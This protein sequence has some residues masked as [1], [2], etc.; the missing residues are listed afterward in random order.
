MSVEKSRAG[1]IGAKRRST[2]FVYSDYQRAPAFCGFLP[3]VAGIHGV[4][5]WAFYVNRGQA[6]VSFGVGSKDGSI[7]RYH[8]AVDAYR[9]VSEEGFRTFLKV[10]SDDSGAPVHYEPFQPEAE[11]V[12]T[13]MI[14]SPD[15]LMIRET[16]RELNL[17]VT[18]RYTT[19]PDE[20][21]A[22]LLREVAVRNTG[23]A[24]LRGEA[25]DGLPRVIPSGIG[26]GVLANIPTTA[27][28]WMEAERHA[29]GLGL[30]RAR[31]SVADT[32]DVSEVR[33]AH[34]TAGYV[35][36]GDFSDVPESAAADRA[37]RG[38]PLELIVDPDLLFPHGT[39]LLH[40]MRFYAQSLGTLLNP[41]SGGGNGAG[42][43][44]T[45][46]DRGGVG[47]DRTA[48]DGRFE[49]VRA[50]GKF[51]CA[52]FATG[53]TIPPGESI[54]LYEIF[55]HSESES[56][57]TDLA[58]RTA[59]PEFFPAA[60]ARSKEIVREIC[61][62]ADTRSGDLVF[63]GYCRQSFLDNVLRGG[64]PHVIETGE[65]PVTVSV[66]GRKHGDLERDYNWFVVPGEPYSQ[67]PGNFR[68]VC[69]N[70]RLDVIHEPRVG[71]D[72]VREFFSLIQTD[73]YNPLVVN[74]PEFQVPDNR[75][76]SVRLQ[77][78]GHP[79]IEKIAGQPF[80]PDDLRAALRRYER[81][82]PCSLDESLRSILG[83]S[84]AVPRAEHGEGF[85]IDHWTY[86][87]D[88]LD[89]YRSVYPEREYELY[90]GDTDYPYF[91]NARVVVPRIHKWRVDARGLRQHGAVFHDQ[92]KAALL[93][94]RGVEA[95]WMRDA[96]GE[97][98]RTTLFEK[99][100][101]LATVKFITRDPLGIGLE[102][103]ADRPGWC[104]ALNGLPG[105]LGSSL[106]EIWDLI[107]L[108][109]HIDAAA[110]IVGEEPD[111]QKTP[112]LVA[113]EVAE[114]FHAAG[115][116]IG[117]GERDP[118]SDGHESSAPGAGMR[119]SGADRQSGS[120]SDDELQRRWHRMSALREEYRARTKLGFS[121]RRE[122]L[123]P[124]L[125]RRI[126]GVMEADLEAGLARGC[127]LAGGA[128]PT[129]LVAEPFDPSGLNE[130][131][132]QGK[133]PPQL[134]FAL[135]ALPEYLEGHTKAI[136]GARSESQARLIHEH[137]LHGPLYDRKLGM[138]RLNASLKDESV[139]VG[140]ARSFTPGWL[141]NESIWLHMEYKYLLALLKAG[142]YREFWSL[143]RS[144]LVPFLD[145]ETY[146]R[147][148]LE[149][150]SFLVASCHPDE[151]L[152]GRGFVARLTGA[153][154]EFLH[155]RFLCL[156][157]RQP[158]RNTGRGLELRFD[159]VLPREMFD[160]RGTLQ[161]RFLTDTTVAFRLEESED[162]FPDSGIVPV[163][164]RVHTGAGDDTEI[165]GAKLPSPW[166]DRIRSGRIKK[167]EVVFARR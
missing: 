141:E 62:R 80:R 144:A 148:T 154:A 58:R 105:L 53:F 61:D 68:D 121:G 40:P 102:M 104:D 4:P 103:E 152:H 56:L 23:A 17:E 146:G 119:Q 39:R 44:E 83:Q 101:C 97:S 10:F 15:S 109:G 74:A 166:A 69:Q 6:I 151:A 100:L 116:L 159:P 107:R 34:F 7:A 155:M 120:L 82:L 2:S 93:K 137:V 54:V 131:L 122:T 55:G 110:T 136:A 30:F 51:P 33:S 91:D 94:Q 95:H 126:V 134:R 89:S 150:C 158:F 112:L 48:S 75:R 49:P 24:P 42:G 163:R 50:D 45:A 46:G 145:P 36:S 98:Y 92:E 57:A 135:R 87:V 114:L 115:E 18:V 79:E 8:S 157:G 130:E 142:L 1:D 84:V 60:C 96:N 111:A 64:F 81:E 47:G 29:S 164:Y 37:E 14:T 127:E 38:R 9:A 108:L 26:H 86:A 165:S 128:Y 78:A 19:L 149:N 70:R 138:L 106:S 43:G 77:F 133:I 3:G 13:E 28:A 117:V 41:I 99:L 20:P 16:K 71:R 25:I 66:F 161:F 11:G 85:W 123:S 76:E 27:I 5:L 167:I 113:E 67:G 35:R 147:S 153:T 124:E 65:R 125:V 140:R 132:A 118:E 139:E 162:L 160:E 143:A 73:G 32:T 90:F 52:L 12:D 59:S 72:T 129:Y 156:V 88:L 21:V 63:D 31:A 22:A